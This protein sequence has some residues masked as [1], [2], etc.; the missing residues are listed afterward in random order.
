MTGASTQADGPAASEGVTIARRAGVVSGFTLLSRVAGYVRDAAMA[1]I[2]GAGVANDAFVAAQTI[3]Y[4]LR[5]LVAEGSLMI[6]FV[7]LLGAEKRAGGVPAMR[8]FYAAVLGALLPL[9]LG[10]VVLG[11]AFPQVPVEVLAGGFDAERK[12]LAT[13]LTRLMMPFLLF[14]SLTAVASGALNVQGIFGPPAAA[15]ILLN[16]VMITGAVVGSMW[17]DVPIIAV[18]W[19]LSLGGLAQLL[20]Q[21]PYLAKVGLLVG[22]RWDPNHAALRTLLVRML[23]A[24]FGVAVYQ[25]NIVVIRRIASALPDGQLSCYFWATRLE[26]FAL[27]VFAVSISIAALPTLSDHAARG[28]RAALVATYRRA[29]RATNFITV[30]S[31]VGLFVLAEPIVGVLFRHGRFTAQDGL[32]TADLAAD[33]GG[34]TD[35]DRPRS[36][37]GSDLLRDRR[38]ANARRGRDGISDRHRGYRRVAS[39]ESRDRWTDP[40]HLGGGAGASAGS[41]RP[42]RGRTS[43]YEA[44]PAPGGPRNRWGTAARLRAVPEGATA[45]SLDRRPRRTVHYRDRAGGGGGGRAGRAARV[46]GRRQ[47]GRRRV[48]G[49]PDRGG[50]GRLCGDG[51]AFATGGGRARMGHDSP[52]IGTPRVMVRGKPS[53]NPARFA[54]RIG[55][56]FP[57][58]RSESVSVVDKLWAKLGIS[59]PRILGLPSFPRIAQILCRVGRSVGRARECVPLHVAGA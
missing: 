39:A 40:R 24:V 48:L 23:P 15:P 12:T 30:P 21:L 1:N 41:G 6:A 29:I 44:E 53:A 28:D 59:E 19:A 2:F 31:A 37:D 9:L 45:G 33:Y 3:P 46:D 50:G 55:P 7:P 52:S 25:L 47:P 13:E 16:A 56:V 5:R 49:R 51:K 22:P 11:M 58:S 43:N 10:L 14:V 18:G 27:G 34:R 42:S 57:N 38:H 32:L 36:C 26:E 8:R 4:V 35:S 54:C 17:F 20:L